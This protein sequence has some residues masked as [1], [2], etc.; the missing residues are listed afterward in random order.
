MKHV[1]TDI[2]DKFE[3]RCCTCAHSCT[4]CGD[5][6]Y[7]C[8]IDHHVIPG[9]FTILNVHTENPKNCKFYKRRV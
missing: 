7:F 9:H 3:P 8:D 4:S 1:N 6:T 5:G 2:M